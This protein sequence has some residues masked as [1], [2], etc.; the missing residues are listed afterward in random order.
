MIKKILI[1]VPVFLLV[2]SVLFNVVLFLENKAVAE[3]FE[4]YKERAALSDEVFK[5]QEEKI[6]EWEHWYNNYAEN[7]RKDISGVLQD[8]YTRN[9]QYITDYNLLLAKYQNIVNY[10]NALLREKYYTRSALEDMV[11]NEKIITNYE[12]LQNDKDAMIKLQ[13]RYIGSL[14]VKIHVLEA[15]ILKYAG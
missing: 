15:L 12:Q 1:L 7:M 2:C 8:F 5:A 9:Y 4:A 10:I 3:E 6:E 11:L 14:Q 13:E